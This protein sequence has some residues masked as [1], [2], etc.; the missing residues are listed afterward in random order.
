MIKRKE[1][2]MKAKAAKSVGE[3]YLATRRIQMNC[4]RIMERELCDNPPAQSSCL[5]RQ[6]QNE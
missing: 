3:E 4:Q 1:R 6:D 2:I 5:D